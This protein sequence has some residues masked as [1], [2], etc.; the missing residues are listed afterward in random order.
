MQQ[1][2]YIRGMVTA[3]PE[4]TFTELNI[5]IREFKNYYLVFGVG[6]SVNVGFRMF[7]LVSVGF[8]IF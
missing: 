6:F 3:A 2:I 1:N 5:F 4:G 7:R 8:R